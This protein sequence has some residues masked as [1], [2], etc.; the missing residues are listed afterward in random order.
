MIIVGR[1]RDLRTTQIHRSR[2]GDPECHFLTARVL[3]AAT[4]SAVFVSLVVEFSRV[5]STQTTALQ[6][7]RD[8]CICGES[9]YRVSLSCLLQPELSDSAV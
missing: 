8:Y 2:Y 5:G 6:I 7:T 1:F 9:E 3:R 4:L